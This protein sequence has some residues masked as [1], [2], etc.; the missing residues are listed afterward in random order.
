MTT[1]QKHRYVLAFDIERT[2]AFDT[3]HT[4]A[5]GA[6]V[7]DENFKELDTFLYTC[8]DPDAVSFEDRCKRE[9]WDKHPELLE[10]LRNEHYTVPFRVHQRKMTEQFQVFRRKWERKAEEAKADYYLVSD[11]AIFDGGYINQLIMRHTEDMP[12]PYSA[13]LPHKYDAL[14]DV[15]QQQ[16]GLMRMLDP[17]YNSFFGMDEQIKKAF[18]PPEPIKQHDHMPN[19]DAYTIA[20][21]FQVLLKARQDLLNYNTKKQVAE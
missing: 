11:N 5:I 8:Y 1:T 20:H 19:N 14:H 16:V 7:V 18:S 13:R 3:N 2:G 9:F 12:M 21:S 10:K 4:I 15:H 6:S 17:A